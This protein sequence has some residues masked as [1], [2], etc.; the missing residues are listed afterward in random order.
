M[1]IHTSLTREQIAGIK[2]EGVTMGNLSSHGSRTHKRAFEVGLSGSGLTGG[3]YGQAD[4]KTAVWDEW[5]A[6]LNELYLLDRDARCG[7]RKH[8]IYA[9]A[10]DFH[11]STQYR[12]H[13]GFDM[14]RLCKRHKWEWVGGG[15]VECKREGCDAVRSNHVMA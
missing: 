1:R 7:N 15:Y 5:G 3:R 13:G 8:P 4:F 6:W 11:E 2:I 12:F 9:D 14:S 10:A